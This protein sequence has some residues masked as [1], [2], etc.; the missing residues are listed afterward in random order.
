MALEIKLESQIDQVIFFLFSYFNAGY[1]LDRH[2]PLHPFENAVG[3]LAVELSLNIEHP[4]LGQHHE[5][6]LVYAPAI[7]FY[8]EAMELVTIIEPKFVHKRD[9]QIFLKELLPPHRN[10]AFKSV[11]ECKLSSIL[12]V[13]DL[14]VKS[15]FFKAHELHPIHLVTVLLSVKVKMQGETLGV[16]GNLLNRLNL[17]R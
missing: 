15:L 9:F 12:N 11:I 2:P 8:N 17:P 4:E 5:P 1:G 14:F 13:L 10:H 3:R 16:R 7:L 6:P